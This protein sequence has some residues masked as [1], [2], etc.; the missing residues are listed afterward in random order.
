MAAASMTLWS[1]VLNDEKTGGGAPDLNTFQ[2]ERGRDS[3]R[4]RGVGAPCDSAGS[5]RQENCES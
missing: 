3:D 2:D 5:R 1:V 4:G